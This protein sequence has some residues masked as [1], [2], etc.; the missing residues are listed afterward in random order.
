[1]KAWTD[2]PADGFQLWSLRTSSLITGNLLA[3]WAC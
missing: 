3:R 2:L 1:V